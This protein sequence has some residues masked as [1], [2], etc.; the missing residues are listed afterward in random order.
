MAK[1][2]KKISF[3]ELMK[4]HPE[5]IEVLFENGMHCIGCSMAAQES[6]GDGALAHG[7]D[8]DKLVDAI[9]KKLGEKN[10]K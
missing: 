2:T 7:L 6:L 8:P 9:N 10:G 3:E 1:V 4:K 5:A